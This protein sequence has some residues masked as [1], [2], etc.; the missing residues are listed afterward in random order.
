MAKLPDDTTG[1]VNGWW[2]PRCGRITYGIHLAHGVTPMYLGCRAT[3]DCE[4]VGQSLMYPWNHQFLPDDR[5]PAWL[6]RPGSGVTI[7]WYAP[8]AAELR[9]LTLEQPDVAEH[10]HKGGLL[11]RPLTSDGMRLLE[12]RLAPE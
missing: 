5:L 6:G 8:D 7:E 9:R 4:G 3:P 11:L 10:V 12:A 1:Q 2:C